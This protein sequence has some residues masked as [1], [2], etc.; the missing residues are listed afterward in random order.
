MFGSEGSIPNPDC[1][2]VYNFGPGAMDLDAGLDQHAFVHAVQARDLAVLVLEQRRPVEARLAAQRPAVAARDLEIL[3][4]VRGVGEQLLRDAADVDAGAA[5]AAVLG[6]RYLGAVRGRDTTCTD[7]TGAPADC[8]KIVIES[9]V[10]S[11]SPG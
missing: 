5:E 3:A 11:G 1:I 6:D 10:T 2:L 4:K 8:E 7:S 9:Q